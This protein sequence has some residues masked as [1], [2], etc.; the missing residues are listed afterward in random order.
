MVDLGTYGGIAHGFDAFCGATIEKMCYSGIHPNYA[1]FPTYSE[2]VLIFTHEMGHLFGSRHTHA[3]AWNQNYT[4]IDGCGPAYG[5]NLDPPKVIPY[6]G[7]C[8]GAPVPSPQTGGTIMSY[9]HLGVA[10]INFSNGFGEQPGNFIRSKINKAVCLNAC[11]PVSVAVTLPIDYTTKFIVSDYI[12]GSSPV[13]TNINQFVS[14]DAGKYVQL[15][16]GFVTNTSAGGYFSAYIDGCGGNN[17]VDPKTIFNISPAQENNIIQNNKTTLKV[18]PTPF[19]G[20]LTINFYIAADNIKTSIEIFTITGV[21][22][23]SLLNENKSTSGNRSIQWNTN[24]LSSGTY[25]VVLT[26]DTGKEIKRVVKL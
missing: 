24:N 10:G 2:S 13:I 11:C 12:S 20:R 16:P 9:C 26:T 17:L 21:K 23:K 6:E 14:F 25:L 18:Y 4:A 19:S 1:N 3:C 22:V 7:N 5:G 8:G 15:Q